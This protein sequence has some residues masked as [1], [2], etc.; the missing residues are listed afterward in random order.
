M[1]RPGTILFLCVLCAGPLLAAEKLSDVALYFAPTSGGSPEERAFFDA[2]VPE[3]IKNAHYRVVESRDE[4]DFIVSGV[5]DAN[6]GP[7]PSSSFTLGLTAASNRSFVLELSWDYVDMEELYFWDIGSILAPVAPP[8]AVE[9]PFRWRH[10]GNR[11]YLGV[12]GGVS[13][14]GYSFQPTDDYSYGYGVGISVEGGVAAELRLLRFLSLQLEGDFVY[15]TFKA[16][17][18]GC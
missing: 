4:A 10:T 2:A 16:P 3:E 8:E 6:G 7:D 11:I 14:G 9:A 18:A 1:K 17:R 15:E 13:F 12:R 5:I